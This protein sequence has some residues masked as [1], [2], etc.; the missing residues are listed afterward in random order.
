MTEAL[1]AGHPDEVELAPVGRQERAFAVLSRELV[2]RL[3]LGEEHLL[4]EQPGGVGV[5][6]EGEIEDK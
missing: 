2:E 1:V 4:E 6:G 3:V 5:L